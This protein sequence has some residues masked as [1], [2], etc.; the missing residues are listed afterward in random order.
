MKFGKSLRFL[1]TVLLVFC[2][3]LGLP[4]QAYGAENDALDEVR[5]ILQEQYVDVVP[6]EILNA[7]T[8]EKMLQGLGDKYTEYLTAAEYDDMINSLNMSFSGIGIELEMVQ[9][10]VKVTRIITGYGADKAGIK[11][12]DIILEADGYSLAGKTSEYCAG[13]LRG[14][15][16][17]KVQVKV[18]RNAQI[19][20]FTVVRMKI[21]MPLAEG[22]VLEGHIGYIAVNSFGEDVATQFGKQALALQEKG[23]DCWI[24]DLRNNSGGYT[25]AAMELL[26]YFIGDKSAYIMKARG[27]L[28]I[29]DTAV[30]QAFTMEGPIVLLI[31]GY[32]ASASEIT[33]AALKDYGKATVIGETTYGSGRVK[34][35]IPLS[36]GDYLKMSVYRFFSPYYNPIDEIGIKP[37]L[38]LTGVN[39]LNTAV[40][41]LKNYKSEDKSQD[42]SGYIQL[43]AG[44]YLYPLSVKELR[45]TENWVLGKKI[46]DSAYVTTT[47]KLGGPNGWEPFPEEVLQDR[48]QIYYP[49][50][51]ESGDLKNIPLGK[52]FN[53]SFNREMD[54]NSVTA[55]S[56]ELINTA[57]GERVKC[58]YV[59]V[60]QQRMTVKPEMKLQANTGYWLVIHPTIKDAKG[61]AI[62]GGV[63][64]ATTAK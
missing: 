57:T 28:G 62:T 48:W 16:G 59:F 7:P 38:D 1:M 44:P 11:Q 14:T 56:I 32:T 49:G 37:H 64:S 54:W 58:A 25:K 53:V 15:E 18:K 5:T 42:K 47:L 3:G 33:S 17:T 43:E 51:E 41:M 50:Y 45:Q 26:G 6:D 60:D 63:A 40:L 4:L 39:E 24:I 46:L 10:G 31:N 23:V 35:L 12:G 20:S 55:D 30:K 8:V 36:N 29:V 21:V 52:V 61:Q 27:N 19:Q 22:R 34:A 9:Q 13:K 2:L